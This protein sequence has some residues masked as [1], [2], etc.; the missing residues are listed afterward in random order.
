[1]GLSPVEMAG[2]VRT[3]GH[4]A[5]AADTPIV[6]DNDYTIRVSPGSPDRTT[7]DTVRIF[8]VLAGYRDIEMAF[9]RDF[10]MVVIEVCIGEVDTF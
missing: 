7:L 1:M 2:A 3:G 6:I 5:A 10:L 4:A 9:I 8:A